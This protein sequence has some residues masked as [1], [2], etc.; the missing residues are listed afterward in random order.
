MVS[1]KKRAYHKTSV[2][3]NS[4]VWNVFLIKNVY[5]INPLFSA[6]HK[7]AYLKNNNLIGLF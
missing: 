6:I 1:Y 2:F 4:Q 7:Y 3:S 5:I